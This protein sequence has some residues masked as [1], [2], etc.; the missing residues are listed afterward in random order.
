MK[1]LE[2]GLPNVPFLHVGSHSRY[3]ITFSDY[4]FSWLGQFPRLPLVLMPFIVLRHFDSTRICLM[5][6][7]WLGWGYG[8]LRRSGFSAGRPLLLFLFPSCPLWKEVTMLSPHLTG[9]LCSLPW[10]RSISISYWKFFCM[11]NAYF[12][13]HLLMLYGPRDIY[14]ML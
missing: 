1:A 9:E 14:F 4:V 11:R 3:H 13:P 5:F 7:S 6:S 12:L 2:F 10:R 8:F